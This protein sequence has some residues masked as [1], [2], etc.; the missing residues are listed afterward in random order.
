MNKPFKEFEPLL[1]VVDDVVGLGLSC[2]RDLD[3]VEV[4]VGTVFELVIKG[5]TK[6]DEVEFDKKGSLEEVVGIEFL[7]L[8]GA[9]GTLKTSPSPPPFPPPSS[10]LF[11]VGL[12]GTLLFSSSC[13]HSF[14]LADLSKDNN[15]LEFT[16]RL[17]EGE[18]T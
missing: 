3:L 11:I 13:N 5:L 15:D 12:S 10:N 18:G 17:G 1:E 16:L 2:L 14:L 6:V 7:L 9:L 8:I 4:V